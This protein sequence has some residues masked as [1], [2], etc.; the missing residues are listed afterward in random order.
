MMGSMLAACDESPGEVVYH[1]SSKL[2]TYRGMGAK[3][4]K[5]SQSVRSR[6]G[7]TEHIFV[8][9][10]VEGR[11]VSTGSIHEVVPQLAQAVRQGFQDVGARSADAVRQMMQDEELRMERRSV[12][13]QAE[14]NVHH[15]HSYEK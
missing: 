11:V 15:L 1:N 7:V 14:G 8:P 5:N 2:K 4:N 13:A 6:Y 10:G 12:G 9:Q 3:A